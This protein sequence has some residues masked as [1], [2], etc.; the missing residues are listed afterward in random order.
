M[1]V[2]IRLFKKVWVERLPVA[3]RAVFSASPGP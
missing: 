2:D 1:N 3:E